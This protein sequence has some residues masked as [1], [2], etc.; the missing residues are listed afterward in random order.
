MESSA[1]ALRAL[2]LVGMPGSGKTLC[3]KH[4]EA[5]GFYQF[6]FGSIVVDEVT[7]RG[8]PI[9][10]ENERIVREEF[11]SNEGMDV[12]A[13]RALPYLRAALETHPVIVIDGL[14]SFSEYKTL[15]REFEGGLVVVAIISAR[16]TRY[17]RLAERDERPLT[18]AEAE[19]RDFQEIERLEKGGPIAMADYTLL[20]D[21]EP[22]DL[23]VNLDTLL[24]GLRFY[25]KFTV[26][27]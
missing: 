25:P 8:L 27:N 6:R 17:A 2:A 26:T 4:L 13:K 24:E 23:L 11:R 3:A 15:H 9:T 20:N 16:P 19:E 1:T 7:R 14:Y 22:Q 21:G 18:A 10:P 12:M 5:R